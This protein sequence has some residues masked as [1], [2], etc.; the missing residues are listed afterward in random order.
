MGI[1]NGELVS[2]KVSHWIRM[3]LLMKPIIW[4]LA[5]SLDKIIEPSFLAGCCII[6]SAWLELINFYRNLTITFLNPLLLLLPHLGVLTVPLAFNSSLY[7]FYSSYLSR[8][9]LL[10]SF[11]F[12]STYLLYSYLY[13]NLVFLSWIETPTILHK[14]RSSV[15]LLEGLRLCLVLLLIAP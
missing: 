11:V 8:C 9:N 7:V 6:W 13:F 2:L 1:S 10:C 14:F 12:P 5:R 4:C 3:S 15:V